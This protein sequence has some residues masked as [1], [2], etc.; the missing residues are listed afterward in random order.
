VKLLVERDDVV[1]DSKDDDGRTPL[2]WAAAS[3]H[4]G[5][6][7]PLV[8]RDEDGTPLSWAA[9]RGHE[10][11]AKLLVERDDVF[12]DSKDKRS[13]TP[14]P[15]PVPVPQLLLVAPMAV[16]TIGTAHSAA[17]WPSQCINSTRSLSLIQTSGES[18]VTSTVHVRSRIFFVKSLRSSLPYTW[19]LTMISF[20]DEIVFNCVLS[21]SSAF[22]PKSDS[23]NT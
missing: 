18:F 16:T 5:F 10:A 20:S 19:K 3:G 9:W 4:D 15:V 22:V 8:E 7:C 14:L 21:K 11:V 12:A 6:V 23:L 17:Y 13:R 2:S 1:A